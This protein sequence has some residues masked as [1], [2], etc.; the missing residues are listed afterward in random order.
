MIKMTCRVQLTK[1]LE[2]LCIVT[3]IFHDGCM[4]RPDMTSRLLSHLSVLAMLK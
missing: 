3:V 2:W 1:I 4:H